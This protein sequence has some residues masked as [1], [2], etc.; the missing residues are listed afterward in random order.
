MPID[1]NNWLS[2]DEMIITDLE[3]LK[4]L[5]DD[6]SFESYKNITIHQIASILNNTRQ[7]WYHSG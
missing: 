6:F 4:D 7:R 1:N 3:Y 5:Y 2:R